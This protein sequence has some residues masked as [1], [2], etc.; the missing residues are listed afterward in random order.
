M[1]HYLEL[2]S[3]PTVEAALQDLET[4][5]E[6]GQIAFLEF[7]DEALETPTAPGKW[8]RKEIIGHL[9]DSALNNIQ[10]F[11]RAQ[12]PAHLEHGVLRV[13]GYA[14]NDW[15][16][17]AKYNGRDKIDLIELWDNLNEHILTII[18]DA[19]PESLAVQIVIGTSEPSSLE[20]VFMSYVGH[21]KHHLA[22]LS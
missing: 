2:L 11:T 16:R 4:A 5:L 9:I 12:I 10:R 19:T 6:S 15:I 13:P 17:L 1:V 22:Q 7:E 20:E 18:E 21:V 3:E 8:S 14:Q